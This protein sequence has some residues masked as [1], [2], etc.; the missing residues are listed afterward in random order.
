MVK[1]VGADKVRNRVVM[2]GEDFKILA[3]CKSCGDIV[4][5]GRRWYMEPGPDLYLNK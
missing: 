3:V 4:D 1:A 5:T 2:F